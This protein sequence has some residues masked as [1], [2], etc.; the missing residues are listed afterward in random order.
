AGAMTKG[1]VKGQ[2][3]IALAQGI[4]SAI[5][6]TIAGLPY[7]A[8]FAL[9]LSFLSIIPLGAGIV[10]LPIGFVMI[11]LGNWWQGILIIVGH[12]FVVTNID[13]VLRPMLVPKKAAMNPAL[14]LLSV[15]A[16]I[17]AF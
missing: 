11:L 12:L 13:N 16:G 8:F 17:A 1:M 5:I 7:G 3:T 14:L 6:L 9:I 10:T 15:F 4:T 2:F